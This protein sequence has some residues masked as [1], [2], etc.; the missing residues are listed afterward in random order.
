MWPKTVH[1]QLSSGVVYVVLAY[2]QTISGSPKGH[3]SLLDL[4]Q[5]LS[6][7]ALCWPEFCYM[8]YPLGAKRLQF[9]KVTLNSD[10]TDQNQNS[11]LFTLISAVVCM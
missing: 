7:G 3:Q 1:N 10:H 8:R 4:G 2:A 9:G 5:M 6:V 11:W